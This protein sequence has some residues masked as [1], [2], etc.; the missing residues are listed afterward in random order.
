M[1]RQPYPKSIAKPI[2]GIGQI[3]KKPEMAEAIGRCIMKWSYVDWQMAVLL[4]AM[5][6]TDSEASIAIFLTLR[7]ARAQRE[8]LTA[9]A[10]LTLSG[11]KKEVF[12]ALMIV[13]GSLQSQRADIAHG[14]FG[15]APEFDGLAWIQT[16][17][18]S[19]HWIER[20]RTMRT[21]TEKDEA[22]IR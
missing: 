2:Y 21:P 14:V 19:T 20:F 11:R 4:A 9:V 15:Y 7:N 13:Y 8:V 5:M 12:D 16:K 17:H 1:A 10:D 6:K 22:Q 3:N 18:L